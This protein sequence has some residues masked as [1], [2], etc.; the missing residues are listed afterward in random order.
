M[1]KWVHRQTDRRHLPVLGWTWTKMQV[2]P[3]LWHFSRRV[4][5]KTPIPRWIPTNLNLLSS[6]ILR[7][8]KSIVYSV[9][10]HGSIP[11]A[12]QRVPR[13]DATRSDWWRLEIKCF[14]GGAAGVILIG[15]LAI[16]PPSVGIWYKHDGYVATSCN[17]SPK[18]RYKLVGGF[19]PS[20]KY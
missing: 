5:K 3:L 12:W 17:C 14:T 16:L 9:E 2:E 1:V 20:Q 10:M 15:P 19:N 4:H 8:R 7:P 11:V 13:V 18:H 6:T